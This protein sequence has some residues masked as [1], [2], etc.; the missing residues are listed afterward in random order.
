VPLATMLEE[1]RDFLVQNP[2]EVLV[3]VIEDYATPADV[4]AAFRESGLERFVYRGGVTAPWPTLRELIDSDQ[5][6][7]VFGENDTRGVPW[8][9]PAFETIQETPYT[10]H[11]P[12]EFSCRQNRGGTTAPLFQINH[13]IETTPTPKPSNAAIVNARDFLLARARQCQK[14]RGRLPNILA[15]DFA[16]TGDVVEVAAE[17]NGLAPPGAPR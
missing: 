10:F 8:Y 12:E 4:A 9:H 2:G 15:V 6:L 5:R 16:M 3:F 13:W 17:L 1:V 7:V 11:T 14:E